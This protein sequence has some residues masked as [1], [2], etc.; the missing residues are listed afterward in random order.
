M[1]RQ[2]HG[3]F[4]DK[5]MA[6][7]TIGRLLAE[8]SDIKVDEHPRIAS[9]SSTVCSILPILAITRQRLSRFKQFSPAH[10]P[11]RPQPLVSP[12]RFVETGSRLSHNRPRAA[13]LLPRFCQT[14]MASSTNN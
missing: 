8:K 11:S 2:K 6:L 13:A 7:K 1:I 10:S 12:H 14:V 5:I 4:G 9:L 3:R